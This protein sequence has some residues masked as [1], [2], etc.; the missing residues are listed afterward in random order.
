M[1]EILRHYV[2]RDKPGSYAYFG[3]AIRHLCDEFVLLFFAMIM[4][5]FTCFGA[6]REKKKAVTAQ[7]EA[8]VAPRKKIFGLFR[9]RR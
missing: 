9:V 4:C 7:K 6:R 2:N 3:S 5:F 8:K 1:F